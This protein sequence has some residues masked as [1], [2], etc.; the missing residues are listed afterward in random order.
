MR[1]RTR[2][3]IALACA[4]LLCLLAWR[5]WS[6]SSTP[7]L[8]DASLAEQRALHATRAAFARMRA[9]V[10]AVRSA[11]GAVGGALVCAACA[12]CEAIGAK[13][14]ACTRSDANGRYTFAQIA[15]GGYYVHATATGY[16]PGSA[17]GGKPLQIA[18]SHGHADVDIV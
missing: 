11:D 8:R 10:P 3:V 17:L 1:Y 18:A 5:A 7:P 12:G 6:T 13:P 9:S 16:R 14:S 2:S 4:A 15:P